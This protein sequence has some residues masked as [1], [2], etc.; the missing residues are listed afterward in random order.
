MTKEECKKCVGKGWSKLIDKLFTILKPKQ[1]YYFKE[2]YGRMSVFPINVSDEVLDK[3]MEIEAE[4]ERTCE[5]CGEEGEI[6]N[7]NG[8]LTCLCEKCNNKKL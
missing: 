7:H 6:R 8:W 1:I 3:V 5:I 2:K 4:S